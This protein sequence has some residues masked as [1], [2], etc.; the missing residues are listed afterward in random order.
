MFRCPHCNKELT[1]DDL[2]DAIECD[3]RNECKCIYCEGEIL[4]FAQCEWSLVGV[5]KN[6]NPC[7]KCADYID[8]FTPNSCKRWLTWRDRNDR[9]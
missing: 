3:G 9:L 8:C 6:D 4:A 2:E 7:K 5:K 1:Y